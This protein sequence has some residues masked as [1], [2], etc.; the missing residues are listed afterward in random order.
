MEKIQ[1]RF[2]SALY[3]CLFGIT[4]YAQQYVVGDIFTYTDADGIEKEYMVV[5]ENLV[6][7]PDFNDGVTDWT[8]GDGNPIG[9][10]ELKTGGAVDGG[11]YLCPGNGGKGANA[12]IGTTWDIEIGKTYL[13]SFF[14]KNENDT[15]AKNPAGDGYIM[16]STS[17]KAREE[18]LVL[19]PLPHVDEGF[20]WTQNTWVFTAEHT[21]LS[22]CARWLNSSYGFDSFIL[23]EVVENRAA[24][25][26]EDILA[27][28]DSW[29]VTFGSAA[30]GYSE[31]TSVVADGYS[32]LDTFDRYKPEEINSILK[33]LAAQLRYFRIV[34]A[35][36]LYPVDFTDYM[37]NPQFDDGL[38]DWNPVNV[39]LNN[40][41]W[42][43]YFA[44]FNENISRCCE[45]NGAPSMATSI[46]QTISGLPIGFYRFSLQAVMQHDLNPIGNSDTK[47]GAV[48]S[49]NGEE[50]DIVTYEITMEGASFE[51]SYPQ[52]FSVESV[53]GIDSCANIKFAAYP[54]ANFR[55]VAIDNLKLEY[56]G[57]EG[58]DVGNLTVNFPI[59]I[60]NSIYKNMYIEL[61]TSVGRVINRYLIGDK[62]AYTF[63]RLDNRQA[64]N[65]YLKNKSGHILG[66]I[67]G[68]YLADDNTNVA[69]ESLLQP[70]NITIS[71]L[72]SD[73]T[74]VTA[75]SIVTW[76][77]AN[78]SC[79]GRDAVLNG[80]VEDTEVKYSVKLSKELAMQ[81]KQPEQATYMV[82]PSG[83][84]I[85][86]V[87]EPFAS[88]EVMG[89][90]RDSVTGIPVRDAM[91]TFSQK[92]NGE[93]A[94]ITRAET[95]SK[96]AF[97]AT[98]YDVPAEVTVAAADYI[99]YTMSLD[100]H[101]EATAL[102]DILMKPISGVVVSVGFTYR[103]SVP[104]GDTPEILGWYTDYANVKYGILNKTTGLPVSNFS[105][106]YPQL[107]LLDGVSVGDEL[108]LTVVSRTG[109][110]EPTQTAVVV[111]SAL[112]CDATFDIVELG[113]I[114]ASYTS[115]TNSA[116]VGILYNEIG[117]MVQKRSYSSGSLTLDN[118]RDGSYTL[119]TMGSSDYFNAIYNLSQ[120]SA[121]GLVEGADYVKHTVKVESGVVSVVEMESVP[122]FDE[123]KLYYTGGDT[124]FTVNKTS[125]TAG[126]YLTL[127]GKIDFKEEY[128]S[129]VSGVSMVIDLPESAV[130][131]D[132]SVMVGAAVAAY[133]LEGN[134]LTISLPNNY[135]E[136]VRFCIIPTEGGS[137]APTAFAQFTIDGKE[138]L[139]PIGSAHYTIKDLSI[140]VP[141]ISGKTIVVSG[142]A[143]GQ[144]T[145]QIYDDDV[146]I[147]ETTSLANG[148]WNATCE[149]HEPYNLSKHRIH[150]KVITSMGL[151]LTSEAK[152]CMYDMNAVQVS[153]VTMIN[154]AHPANSPTPCEYVTVFDFLHPAKSIP[155]YWYWPDYPEFTFLMEFTDNDT[156]KVSNVVLWVET[157]NGNQVPLNAEYD[158]N[159][160]LW[161]ASGNFGSWSNYDIPTNVSLDF[162]V[163]SEPVFDATMIEDYNTELQQT[164]VL[165]ND[166]IILIETLHKSLIAELEKNPIDEDRIR[167]IND[168]ID[169]LLGLSKEELEEIDKEIEYL[170]TIWKDK[171]WVGED[172]DDSEEKWCYYVSA[173]I[174]KRCDYEED[175]P[176]HPNPEEFIDK[177][178]QG[179]PLPAG[180]T[181]FVADDG[182]LRITYEKNAPSDN[183]SDY[184][185]QEGV[186]EVQ[187]N[188]DVNISYVELVN[189]VSKDRIILDASSRIGE[190]EFTTDG[191]RVLANSAI[192]VMNKYSNEAKFIAGISGDIYRD[193]AKYMD[194]NY[195]M[196]RRCLSEV[197]RLNRESSKRV[198]SALADN[199]SKR[200]NMAK[201]LGKVAG[202]I[203][204]IADVWSVGKDAYDGWNN[205]KDWDALIDRIGELCSE[206]A[207]AD[208]IKRAKD[209]KGRY[210]RRYA[211]KT[212]GGV[213]LTGIEIASTSASGMTLGV[214]LL[215]RA[216]S[217]GI[218]KG[219]DHW[220][221]C[222]TRDDNNRKSEIR[223]LVNSNPDCKPIDDDGNN[224]GEHKSNNPNVGGVH[225]PSGYVY[226]GVSSNRLEGVMAL[227]YYKETVEDIY[228]DQHENVVLWDAEQYA[229]ENPLFTDANGMYRWD[230][231]KGL[232]QVKFEKEGYETT[233]SEWL[234]VPPPQLEVNIPMVQNKQPEVA[235]VHAYKDGVEIEFD[236]YMQPATLNTDNIF[237]IQNGE[238]VAGKVTLL[239]EEVAYE[240]QSETY[241]SKVRFVFDQ[242]VT[243]KEITLTVVN[244]VK[245]YAGLQMQD[246]YTQ[247]FA[248]EQE[249]EGIVAD[250]LVSMYY[251]GEQTLT[252]KV[253]PA[254]AAAGKTLVVTSSSPMILG[255]DTDSIVLDDSGEA[256]LTVSGELPGMGAIS[257]SLVGYDYRASTLVEV[258]Y[259]NTKMTANPTASIASG[260]T[261]AK[262]TEVTLSCTTEGAAIYYTLDGSCPCD[263]TAILYDGTPIV[264][265]ENTELR[266]M[267]VAEGMYESD[268]VVYNY[269]VEGADVEEV[270]LPF[271]IDPTV[272]TDGFRV[273]GIEAE[274]TV[275]VY[276][277]GGELVMQREHVKNNTFINIAHVPEGM[278][279]VVV[280]KDD[281]TH[282]QRILKVK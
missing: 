131:V 196:A 229:Q 2:I 134:R 176:D 49:L 77:D 132:N 57:Q 252:V 208:I 154:V 106:Q 199:Y 242:A 260:T 114:E 254:A 223:G 110:F 225:D 166:S 153:K 155:D 235:G 270:T 122:A 143:I 71:V 220:K 78:G 188:S 29:I 36:S 102:G 3:A 201:T 31:F 238:K 92:L 104:E 249:V 93:Y 69:F 52:E 10:Y 239:N 213:S 74:D 205:A 177:L 222:Y 217:Y 53:V 38:V 264:I 35:S 162:D 42:Y 180:S 127:T 90:V 79:L 168:S 118:L 157:C 187:D 279:I 125:A 119:V 150:A 173:Y 203:G 24:K 68:V 51:N 133:T 62:Q 230:V 202:G 262:G 75:E 19:Q 200:A 48:I 275:A 115:T 181:T 43:R 147:G 135:T 88:V 33:E 236:K 137:Y 15:N 257:Y 244:S 5:D 234:P 11:T 216:A 152:E 227:C 84:E 16:V 82:E 197:N 94:H 123:S 107:V 124:R 116:V 245:S 184:L 233:Y 96:G 282:K 174:D 280:S 263:D 70:Q 224:G 243:A 28:C 44:Y 160:G 55:Y 56:L 144:S 13:F 158:E 232:W 271:G 237:V 21:T 190:P 39:Q 60:L 45:I 30:V 267:A 59:D 141:G 17:N 198:F 6:E 214:S 247:T 101:T 192:R 256:V 80:Q 47:S 87:L 272:V 8:G 165:S 72:A 146:L 65:V 41:L 195:L 130:F 117:E 189:S 14:L 46:S 103:T 182:N 76:Y 73:G 231:P 23:A 194:E 109:S 161:V 7:N 113:G 89:I 171:T 58:W 221:E 163:I 149:L 248:I 112:Q 183:L 261:V 34:N 179:E 142:M 219:L 120:L 159:K 148:V 167:E 259:N 111:D 66:S 20:A 246:V 108:L 40:G 265:N 61:S 18:T 278:Y 210:M 145:I 212:F 64:Y 25:E 206:S 178:V 26:L 215:I 170:Y 98:L 50:L 37:K 191:M 12:S 105:V 255:V 193:Y 172:G 139:Q 121:V 97:K 253:I 27:E 85:K 250:S 276:G 67:E 269:Y 32:I 251:G 211:T 164:I 240:G 63:Y 129:K 274:C 1:K 277:V 209:Y 136:R 226:E 91:V 140:E 268:V 95:D 54:N 83:N 156:T 204:S 22:L 218:G 185:K 207:S 128:A 9:G 100:T 281:D 138:V 186:W 228:G 4:S 81:Y 241:A 258:V 86:V 99:S 151:E 126:N 266:I 175:F 273:Q 169:A